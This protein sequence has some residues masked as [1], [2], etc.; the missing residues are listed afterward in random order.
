MGTHK[1][2]SSYNGIS[3]NFKPLFN[4][5]RDLFMYDSFQYRETSWSISVSRMMNQLY[6][7][8]LAHISVFR[9][10]SKDIFNSFERAYS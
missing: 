9:S 6:I 4:D 1:S 5:S 10:Y 7:F 3:L 2:A 8:A